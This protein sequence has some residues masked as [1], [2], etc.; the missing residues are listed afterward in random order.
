MPE[1]VDPPAAP[2]PVEP[3]PPAA[4]P[5]PEVPPLSSDR[6][7]PQFRKHVDMTSPLPLRGMAA[8]GLVPL[9]PSDTCHCLAMLGLDPDSGIAAAARKSAAGLPDKI[10]SIGLRDE[11][12]SP[13]TLHFFAEQLAGKDGPLEYVVLNNSSHDFTV[14]Q[15]VAAT[16]SAKLI[17]IVANNQLRILRDERVL[18]SLVGNPSA[19]K[20][21]VDLTCDFAV[22]SGLVLTDL[23]AMVEAHLRIHGAPPAVPGSQQAAEADH[24][25]ALA[26]MA[27]FGDS[28]TDPSAPPME[29]PKRLN[30][31]QRIGKMSIAEK[32][33]LSSL[34]NKEAR[35]ILMRDPNKIV[36]LSV[37]HS[38]R[39]SDGEVLQLAHSKTCPD[40]VLRVIINARDWTR[41]YP[42]KL[43]LVKN[44]KVPLAIAMRLMSTLRDSEVK[45]LA[46]NKNIPSGIRMQAK[47]MLEKKR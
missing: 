23:P 24:N 37:I 47:K 27:E 29:D 20:A 8:K 26:V 39:I 22:R 15:I 46:G 12:Q 11:T 9:S 4:D 35:A 10:L 13:R 41:Q 38:P 32:I 14:A 36:A 16:S 40:D 6:L 28:V 7:P 30:L 34:G 44:P 17:D 25:T 18:R 33:K 45:E 3:P 5:L 2:A 31:T 1:T 43:A 42:I 21:V 19:S